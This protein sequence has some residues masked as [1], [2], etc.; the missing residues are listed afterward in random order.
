MTKNKGKRQE[1]NLGT[2]IGE[3][4]VIWFAAFLISI[5]IHHLFHYPMGIRYTVLL[6]VGIYLPLRLA[7]KDK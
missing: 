7:L 2:A 5:S 3:A 4:L 6:I 1:D